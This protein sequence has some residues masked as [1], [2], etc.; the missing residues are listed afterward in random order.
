MAEQG[1]KRPEL[2][3]NFEK[4]NDSEKMFYTNP[5]RWDLVENAKFAEMTE[6]YE[7]N[8]PYV[9]FHKLILSVCFF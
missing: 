5:H 7:G 2:P 4:L 8:C 6:R 9:Y 1:D 3:E